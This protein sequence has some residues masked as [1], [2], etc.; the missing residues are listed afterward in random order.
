MEH[1]AYKQ[2]TQIFS[3]STLSGLKPTLLVTSH[4]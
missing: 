1:L 4:S 2:L 3:L